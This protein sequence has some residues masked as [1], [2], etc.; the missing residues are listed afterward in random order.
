MCE[1]NKCFCGYYDKFCIFVFNPSL[2][3]PIC[4]LGVTTSPAVF[5][6]FFVLSSAMYRIASVWFR[7]YIGTSTCERFRV[8]FQVLFALQPFVKPFQEKSIPNSIAI[9]LWQ[10]ILHVIVLGRLLLM[11]FSF[12]KIIILCSHFATLSPKS[13]ISTSEFARGACWALL[14]NQ[15]R[16]A[17]E[18]HLIFTIFLWTQA[19]TASGKCV[20][21]L[22]ALAR[23]DTSSLKG[24]YAGER[25]E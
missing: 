8:R 12:K 21:S 16:F 11:L 24:N 7:A 19:L 5:L 23:I 4:S 17:Q 3:W 13:C 1:K 2:H 6:H 25:L 15:S 9:H 10:E 22:P 14:F 20:F 18:K